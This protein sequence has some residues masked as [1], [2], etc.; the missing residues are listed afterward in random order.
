MSDV[1]HWSRVPLKISSKTGF[2]N[3]NVF[4]VLPAEIAIS[5]TKIA[6]FLETCSKTKVTGDTSS[7]ILTFFR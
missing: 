6:K 1:F 5:G 2:V 4:F 7:V 3:L